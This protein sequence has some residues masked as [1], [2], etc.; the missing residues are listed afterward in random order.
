MTDPPELTLSPDLVSSLVLRL[1][2]VQGREAISDP[3]S[4]S[5][6]IDDGMIDALQSS[7]GDLSRQEVRQQIADLSPQEQVQLVALLW[8]GRGDF[9][10][11][12]WAA[13]LRLAEDQRE[14]PTSAYILGQPLAADFLA[15]GWDQMERHG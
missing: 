7:S 11:Q 10:P 5:N 13:A 14:T 15:E 1:R 6:P 9:A 12:E 8:V 2:A 3:N 4:G